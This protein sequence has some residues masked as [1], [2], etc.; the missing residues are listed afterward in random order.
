M[1]ATVDLVGVRGLLDRGAHLVEVLPSRGV[2][3]ELHL[4]ALSIFH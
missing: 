3:D 4:L 1:A 2:I